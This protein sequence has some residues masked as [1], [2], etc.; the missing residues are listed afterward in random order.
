MVDPD[1][2][3]TKRGLLYSTSLDK[4]LI[5]GSRSRLWALSPVPT[6]SEVSLLFPIRE[7]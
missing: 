1:G 7:G 3:Y 6:S 4:A 5:P 2:E